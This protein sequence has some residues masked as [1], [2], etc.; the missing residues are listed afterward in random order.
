MVLQARVYTM[1][2]SRDGGKHA[3]LVDIQ[4]TFI[5]DCYI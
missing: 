3:M 1:I 4:F 5:N 2:L